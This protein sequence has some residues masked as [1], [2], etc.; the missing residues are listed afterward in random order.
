[1][2]KEEVNEAFKAMPFLSSLTLGLILAFLAGRFIHIAL[3]GIVG[4]HERALSLS[5]ISLDPPH[6]PHIH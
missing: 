3:C 5:N 1:M 4:G 2:M 6:E